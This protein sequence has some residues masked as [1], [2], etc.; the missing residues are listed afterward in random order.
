M[1]RPGGS[2]KPCRQLCCRQGGMSTG[3]AR[4]RGARVGPH[5]SPRRL[6]SRP[7]PCRAAGFPRR[8]SNGSRTPSTG[9][10]PISIRVSIAA[11]R[12][13]QITEVALVG[14]RGHVQKSDY[15]SASSLSTVGPAGRRCRATGALLSRPALFRDSRYVSSDPVTTTEEHRPVEL[16]QKVGDLAAAQSFC[17][18]T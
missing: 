16:G 14:W 2:S 17:R 4:T 3:P 13:I 18:E 10:E 11:E 8:R 7:D 15:R 1:G 5:R 9:S 12:A 6:D